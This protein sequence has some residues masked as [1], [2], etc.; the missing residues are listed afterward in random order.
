MMQKTHV[1][2]VMIL[3]EAFAH[4]EPFAFG[5]QT[6]AGRI[7]DLIPVML[8]H[9]LC[10]PPEETYSL[11]RKMAGSFLLCNKINAT[12]NCKPMFDKVWREYRFGDAEE[13]ETG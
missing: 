12:V 7:H 4:N 6:T 2:A 1:D 3:G 11:H 10:P 13:T 8:N 5:K 9:R